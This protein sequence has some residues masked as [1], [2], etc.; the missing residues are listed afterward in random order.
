MCVK[1][2]FFFFFFNN[3][4]NQRR[5]K[6]VKKKKTNTSSGFGIPREF[7]SSIGC[8]SGRV[9]NNSL[10]LCL[11][12]FL[13]VN[14]PWQSYL[15][16]PYSAHNYKIRTNVRIYSFIAFN[17]NKTSHP[18]QANNPDKSDFTATSIEPRHDKTCLREFPTRPDS[19]RPAQ[20]HKLA[21]VLKFRLL[22][23]LYYLSSEQQM[24]WSHC[25]F[26]VR[27]WHKTPFLMTRLYYIVLVFMIS[28]EGASGIYAHWSPLLFR[29]DSSL[30]SCLH[31]K[32]VDSRIFSRLFTLLYIY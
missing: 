23:I 1:Y 3:S 2:F 21:R 31:S 24:R 5:W 18:G 30:A 12:L 25:A 29:F 16:T 7:T 15:L 19:N 11:Y 6:V 10:C 26:V 17:L 27:I 14:H 13:W 8:N 9:K 22:E 32:T 20:P 28:S 4:L